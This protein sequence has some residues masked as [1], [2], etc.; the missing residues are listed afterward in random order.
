ML[1]VEAGNIADFRALA[2]EYE[3]TLPEDLRHSDVDFIPDVALVAY[4][5]G[6]PRGCVALVAH[7]DSTGI[8]KRLYV[9]PS[10]RNRGVARGLVAALVEAA[11]ARGHRRIVLDTDRTRLIEAYALYQSLGF[12]ECAPYAPV[13]YAMPTF[14]ELLLE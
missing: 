10:A 7:D 9:Q 4:L 12:R 5:E 14:M 3:A 13:D 1:R 2:Y 8:M 6:I 11:R